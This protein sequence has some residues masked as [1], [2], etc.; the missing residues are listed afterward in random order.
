MGLKS[1]RE[2]CNVELTTDSKYVADGL[3][4][5]WAQ[6]WKANGWR[7]KD[8]KP[9]LN[10]DLWEELLALSEIHNI[11]I[12]WVKGHAGHEYNERCDRLAV[13]YYLSL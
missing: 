2:P 5:G 4:K 13:N 11:N 12:H 9:A 8:K 3:G 6:S 7:K 1:L 10:A